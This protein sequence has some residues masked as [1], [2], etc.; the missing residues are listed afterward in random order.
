L[1]TIVLHGVSSVPDLYT[2]TMYH[3]RLISE[4]A[5]APFVLRQMLLGIPQFTLLLILTPWLVWRATWTTFTERCMAAAYA[6]GYLYIAARTCFG[7]WYFMIL[8]PTGAYLFARALTRWD[9]SLPRAGKAAG[10]AV[11]TL[12]AI[13]V[14]RHGL[15]STPFSNLANG[16]DMDRLL[17]SLVQQHVRPG[18]AVLT[19]PQFYHYVKRRCRLTR[20]LE[21]FGTYAPIED[22]GR[23]DFVL[24]MDEYDKDD[25]LHR[26][27]QRQRDELLRRFELVYDSR[28]AG[29]Q[30]RSAKL[31][32]WG[33]L[34][35]IP[36]IHI[37]RAKLPSSV[38]GSPPP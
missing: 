5:A 10:V 20:D 4:H 12:L 8:A 9:A 38:R 30:W 22:L 34:Q 18:S 31:R 6:A 7:M 33:Q 25:P 13:V 23:F 1:P 37:Y 21:Y 32:T 26:L 28:A 11:V 36:T 2:G 29:V 14:C 19:S 16:R 27:D 3:L 15:I 35:P 24:C 17:A